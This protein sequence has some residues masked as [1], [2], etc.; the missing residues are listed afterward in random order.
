MNQI[1][2]VGLIGGGTGGRVFHAPIITSVS[3]LKLHK[4][5]TTN[6]VNKVIFQERFNDVE[7][8]SNVDELFEDETIQLIVIA[9]PNSSHY[10]LALKALEYG[11]NVVVEKPF[12]VTTEE[13]DYLIEFAQQKNKLLTVYHNRRWDSDFRT[14]KKVIENGM[15]G[16]IV[17]YEAHF[18]RFRN[19]F[20]NVWK[21]QP[22]PGSGILYDLGSH[23]IDQAQCLFGVPDE[24]FADIRIQKEGGQTADNFEVILSY[25]KIKVTLKAGMLVRELGPHFT[26][27]GTKGSFVKYGMDVQEEALNKGYLP[28]S[29]SDWGKEPENLWGKINT[30]ID[31]LH[32]IGKI[33]SELGDYR[34]F[35]K[36]V[37]KALLGEEEL[38]VLPIQARNTIKIIELAEKSSLEKRWMKW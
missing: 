11:K 26:I 29:T 33:E 32:L 20:K 19:F 23:L 3:G 35:Y 25:P 13:A 31:G 36:N 30:E 4:V 17:E 28:K 6:E 37:Y 9:T 5:Y 10:E 38:E 1:I 27:L 34:E 16:D 14:V 22:L 7:I 12:T 21:E 8:T 2:N 18:D 24:V 15:L